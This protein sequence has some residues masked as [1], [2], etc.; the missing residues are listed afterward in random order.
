MATVSQFGFIQT[1]YRKVANGK[2][3]DDIVYLDAAEEALFTIAQA[4]ERVDEK[5]GKFL[6]DQVLCRS[7]EG[8]AVIANAKDVD[9][10]DVAPAQIVSVATA[11]IPFLEHNDANRALMGANMQRQAVPLM[12]PQAPLVGTGVEHRAAVDSGD[13]VVSNHAGTVVE[14]DATRV[15]V[16]GRGTR[17]EYDLT[18]FM[19]SNQGTLIHHKPIGSRQGRCSRTVPRPTT[20]SSRSART[21]SSASCRSRATTSRTRSSSR[22]GS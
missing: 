15:V 3:S 6:H 20:V 16:E 4:S 17:D 22:S 9:F 2:V 1:P 13:V 18:K 11:M 19:R 12:I 5:T 21:C 8:E 7:A 10:M 14:L